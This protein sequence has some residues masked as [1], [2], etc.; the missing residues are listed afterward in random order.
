MSSEGSSGWYELAGVLNSAEASAIRTGSAGPLLAEF[1]KRNSTTPNMLRKMQRSRLFIEKHAADLLLTLSRLPLSYIDVLSRIH[2]IETTEA[3]RLADALAKDHASFTYRKLL[4][5][6]DVLRANRS[7]TSIV[8]SRNKSHVAQFKKDVL[9]AATE[10]KLRFIHEADSPGTQP[11]VYRVWKGSHAFASPYMTSGFKKAKISPDIGV[12]DIDGYDC[13]L[14]YDD[15]PRDLARDRVMKSFTE[16]TFF[17]RFWIILPAGGSTIYEEL[18]EGL[19]ASNLGVLR[20]CAVTAQFSCG[21]SPIIPPNP[22]RRGFW[23][24]TQLAY[25]A[26]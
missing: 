13:F 16:A 22:D 21:L 26:R 20:F 25:C 15:D 5:E 3:R 6:Y 24:C 2:S 10:G 1:A 18:I 14:Q 4:N 9:H 11:I 17:D 12:V 8:A 19:G 7:K 23:T